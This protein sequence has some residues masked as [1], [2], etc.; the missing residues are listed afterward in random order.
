MIK[1]FFHPPPPT[2]EVIVKTV[3]K[4]R[5]Q[6]I[7]LEQVTIRL[8]NRDRV[9]FETCVAEVERNRRERAAICANEIAEV[10]KLLKIVTQCQLALQRII[11]RLET[12]KELGDVLADLRPTLRAL[13]GLTGYLEKIMPDIAVEL[14]KVND[15]IT[16]TLAVSR[17]DSPRSITPYEVGS[18][19]GE[20]ILKEVS[21]LLE[22]QLMG[23]LPEPPA[24]VSAERK[25]RI[26]EKKEVVALAASC[27]EACVQKEA[28]PYFSYKDVEMRKV[29]FT[30]QRSSLEDD[31]LEYV[32]RCNGE[33]DVDQCA[34]NLNAP[35]D[36]VMK[37]LEGLGAR[38]RIKILR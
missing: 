6:S 13:Q 2:S 10:R 4:L 26:E 17:L 28:E 11:L 37:T 38:G 7:K 5:F 18:P 24:P 34:V 30:I 8:R 21:N 9:L 35:R 14:E 1:N 29:S 12:I 16:E 15:S 19:A 22:G 25:A 20:E 33:F 36:E 31:V 23:K 3:Q 32:K 27:S